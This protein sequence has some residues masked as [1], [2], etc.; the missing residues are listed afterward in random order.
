MYYNLGKRF[1]QLSWAS[2]KSSRS[3]KREKENNVLISIY[4]RPTA[5]HG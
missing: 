1:I 3:E 2:E 5:K 4:S